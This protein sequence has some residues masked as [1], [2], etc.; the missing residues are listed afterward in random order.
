M[1]CVDASDT[2]VC[3]SPAIERPVRGVTSAVLDAAAG[4]T[5][6]NPSS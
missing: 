4:V 3:D 6:D 5:I 1:K 2:T